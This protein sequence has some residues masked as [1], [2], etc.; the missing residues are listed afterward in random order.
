MTFRISSAIAEG[1]Q[2]LLRL[3]S[4]LAIRGPA[5]CVICHRCFGRFL[6]YRTGLAGMSP[7][8]GALDVIGSDVENYECPWCGAH[9]RERH[10]FL[11]L[12]A[13]GLL[14]VAADARILHFAPE[15]HLARILAEGMP[16]QYVR[17]DLFPTSPQI[18]RLDITAIAYP[19]DNFDLV[20]ANHVMEHVPD[21]M[22][23]L[24]ELRRV[25]KPG[26]YAVLQTPYSASLVNSWSDPG[27]NTASAR[28]LAFG[29]E[30]HVRL[31]GRDIFTRFAAA[32]FEARVATHREL[33][34]RVDTVR[35]GV[36]EREPF[37]LFRKPER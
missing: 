26:A 10:L 32:G 19:D 17:G 12:R 4:R 16:A 14:P 36:N 24:T 8:M 29:Q 18:E 33:L 13:A 9:D 11:Y 7:L 30:D 2:N 6:P 20:L 34:P 1:R 22:R 37:M 31:Y 28:Q 35:F 15:R 3:R 23:A 27:I 5:E 25:L 21:D